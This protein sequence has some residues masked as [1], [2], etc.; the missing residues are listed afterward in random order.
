MTRAGNVHAY[1]FKYD[2]HV[3]VIYKH[4]SKSPVSKEQIYETFIEPF[5]EIGMNIN[6][7]AVTM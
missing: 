3:V 1:N 4:I 5:V 2:N 6:V 7:D